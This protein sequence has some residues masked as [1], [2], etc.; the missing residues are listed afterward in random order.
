MQVHT[1]GVS[2]SLSCSKVAGFEGG[3]FI[4]FSRATFLVSCP[5]RWSIYIW[6]IWSWNKFDE[7]HSVL[8]IKCDCINH[9]FMNDVQ[10]FLI[11]VSDI[12][13]VGLKGQLISKA[14]YGL[15]TSPKKWT[16]KFVLFAFSL[17]TA[18]KS[19]SSICFLGESTVRQSALRF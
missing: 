17:F 4:N 18:N 13:T 5:L 2:P 6:A 3:I 10:K 12:K 7:K 9:G 1:V 11:N 16:D 19:N 8:A 14:I 15:I